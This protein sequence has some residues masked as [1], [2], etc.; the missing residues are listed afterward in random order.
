MAREP[1][2]P[3]SFAPHRAF[4]SPRPMLAVFS[5]AMSGAFEALPPSRYARFG[6]FVGISRFVPSLAILIGFAA[7]CLAL[8]LRGSL[9]GSV[10][11]AGFRRLR[12]FFASVVSRR[13]TIRLFRRMRVGRLRVLL[14]RNRSESIYVSVLT[15]RV[16]GWGA[17]CAAFTQLCVA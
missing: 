15:E 12:A 9:W 3:G 11:P 7:L 13:V 6:G 1:L 2:W 10:F 8:A 14:E 16:T 5:V 17:A 4:A